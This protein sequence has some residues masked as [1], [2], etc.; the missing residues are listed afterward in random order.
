MGI[1]GKIFKGTGRAIGDVIQSPVTIAS[2]VI[3][4]ITDTCVCGEQLVKGKCPKNTVAGG[5]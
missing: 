3:E 2:G 5:H 4:S 1:L